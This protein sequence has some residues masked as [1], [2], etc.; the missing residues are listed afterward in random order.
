M[1]FKFS[2]NGDPTSFASGSAETLF[3]YPASEVLTGP[4]LL[5]EFNKPLFKSYLSRFDPSNCIITITDPSL[6]P[7][8]PPSKAEKLV[9]ASTEN[10]DVEPW[11][12]APYRQAFLSAEAKEKV[13]HCEE[14]NDELRL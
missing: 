10:W 2:E 1:F 14:R 8:A 7:E 9:T 3:K 6:E 12:R 5:K 11:Y 4:S 13:R